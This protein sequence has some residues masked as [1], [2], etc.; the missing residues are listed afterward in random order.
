MA[1][2]DMIIVIS[3]IMIR[4]SYNKKERMDWTVEC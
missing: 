3:V 4:C 1:M 2:Y